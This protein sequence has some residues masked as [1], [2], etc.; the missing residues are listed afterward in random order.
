VW[1]L[2]EYAALS[3]GPALALAVA[4]AIARP[5][6]AR[7]AEADRP[8][9][10]LWLSLTAWLAI[11]TLPLLRQAS[12]VTYGYVVAIPIA[13][14]GGW[15]LARVPVRAV[16]VALGATVL[17]VV[18]VAV[19]IAGFAPIRDWEEPRVLA[20]AAYLAGER[21]DLLAAGRQA[22]FVGD[23]GC[24]AGQ[25]ARGAHGRLY[26]P[27]GFPDALALTGVGSK[28]ALLRAFVEGYR[29]RG[30]LAADWV[31]LPSEALEAPGRARDF[32]WRLAHDPRLAWTAAF[33][34]E[35]GRTLWLGERTGAATPLLRAPRQDVAR[36]S[37]VYRDRYDRISFL[38]RN[39]RVILHY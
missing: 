37:A 38:K 36:L 20:A 35:R 6:A 17:A 28:E 21:G 8:A 7:P 23:P 2:G 34:D 5:L 24:S 30:E 26:M 1:R 27:L 31:L 19:V 32:Y 18:P 16:F 22:V 3:L 15:L 13:L 25:H 33:R 4:G 12:S 11:F 29:D 10:A 9:A 14:L 39:V